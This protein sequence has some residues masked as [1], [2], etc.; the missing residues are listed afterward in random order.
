MNA[1]IHRPTSRALADH[2]DYFLFLHSPSGKGTYQTYPNT[3]VCLA[4]YECSSVQ[5]D[6]KANTCV[7]TD[8][9]QF[10]ASRLYGFHRRPFTVYHSGRVRQICVLFKGSSIGLF[11]DC[12]ITQIDCADEP[13]KQI[14]ERLDPCFVDELFSLPDTSRQALLLE[15]LL[16]GRIRR[17]PYMEPYLWAVNQ[18]QALNV[19]DGKIVEVVST[20]LAIDASTLYRN[21]RRFFGQ[22]PIEYFQT[23]R[24]RKGLHLTHASRAS[25]TNIA[26]ECDYYDQS[27]FIRDMRARAGCPPSVL[28]RRVTAV[29]GMLLWTK[30]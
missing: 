25:L 11:T 2:I 16:L 29:Q 9:G 30:D 13:I 28:R 12:P 1:V 22:S 18:L 24:F 20:R 26:M 15:K 4:L 23:L 6:Q 10:G 21:F 17:R 7:V 8:T 27:H 19:T 14:F 3:N 5:W